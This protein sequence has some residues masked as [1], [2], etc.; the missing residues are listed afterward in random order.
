MAPAP[1]HHRRVIGDGVH[2]FARAPAQ[3]FVPIGQCFRRYLA[4]EADAVANL[5]AREFPRVAEGEPFLREFLLPAIAQDLPEQP[6]VIADAVA[7]GGNGERRHAFQEARREPPEPAIAQRRVRFGEPCLV[8]RHAEFRQ[9][10][11]Q[12]A[13]QAEIADV[14]AQQPPDQEFERE[15]VDVLPLMPAGALHLFQKALDHVVAHREGGRHEPVAVARLGWRL[16][17]RVG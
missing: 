6:V 11:A 1:A 10:G 15:V 3:A 5:G 17:E 2:P 16:A 9:G 4:A 13:C 14:L 7:K 8:E 12:F